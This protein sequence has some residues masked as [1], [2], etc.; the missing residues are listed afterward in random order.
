L[1]VVHEVESARKEAEIYHLRNVALQ[2]EIHEREKLIAELNAFAH[3]VAHDIKIPTSV[4]VGYSEMLLDQIT[5]TGDPDAILLAENLMKTGYRI[6]CIVDNLLTLA[7]VRQQEIIPQ[8]L[9]MTQIVSEAESRLHQLITE[10]NAQLIK[11]IQWPPA[12][13]H[14]PWIEEVWANYISNAIKYGG[15]PPQ[16]ELGATLENR[17]VRFW[18]R[19]NGVGL[20]AEDKTRLFTEF[21][22][23]GPLQITGYGLGLSIVKRIVEKLGGTVE[24]ESPGCGQ[25][26][27]FSFSLPAAN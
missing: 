2:Q 16:V 26:S 20:S 17:F 8:P 27:T 9:N 22:R 5:P 6:A 7:S 19:D 15:H 11:P 12:L 23:V 3:T 18:V 4:V 10:S 24:V 1:Q 14:A 21:T 25:G 13:G